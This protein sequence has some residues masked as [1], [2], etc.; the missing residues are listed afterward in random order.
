MSTR[1]PE[2]LEAH[3]PDCCHVQ[4]TK[5]PKDPRMSIYQRSEAT[6][7]SFCSVCRF[8]IDSEPENEDVV[9]TQSVDTGIDSSS[10]IFQEHIPCRSRFF[11]TACHV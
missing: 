6:T 3:A 7:R 2:L 9:V 4:R 5:F 1:L 8:R 10:H 11:T